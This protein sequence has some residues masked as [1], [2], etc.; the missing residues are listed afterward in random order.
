MLGEGPVQR[1]LP[2][3]VDIKVG[4]LVH[5][6]GCVPADPGMVVHVVAVGEE[7]FAERLRPGEEHRD[8]LRGHRGAPVGA[9]LL[10]TP[11]QLASLLVD[12][13]HQRRPFVRS[14]HPLHK[15]SDTL[16]GIFFAG[17]DARARRSRVCASCRVSRWF[18]ASNFTGRADSV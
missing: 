7:P 8:G 2:V 1:R 12:H 17:C 11:P 6:R 5:G 4:A 13:G 15:Q 9:L 18:S 16:T 14:R 10:L 3:L